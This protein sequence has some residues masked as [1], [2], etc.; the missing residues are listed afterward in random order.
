MLKKVHCHYCGNRLS[1][2]QEDGRSRL[3]C[4]AC[5]SILYENPVPATAMVTIDPQGRLLLVK[6]S[7]DPKMGFWC[8][9]GG[10]M[11]I[12]E[13]PEGAGLRE[14]EEETGLSG[15][16]DMLLG[17]TAD[18]SERYGTVLMTGYLVRQFCGTLRAGDDAEA[19]EWFSHDR[20][21][22]IA[23][24]SHHRFIKLYFSAYADSDPSDS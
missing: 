11:E 19:A 12:G 24:Y 20:L 13:T 10:F 16:I 8:L 4:A 14:L 2:I 21:P 17:V 18:P 9:P 5:A 6:R 15:K 7:V 1:H 3:Y 22:E 23:F